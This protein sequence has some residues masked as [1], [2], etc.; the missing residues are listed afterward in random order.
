LHCRSETE[1]RNRTGDFYSITEGAD[2][3]LD[4]AVTTTE[5][6]GGSTQ[7]PRNALLT[8]PVKPPNE[9]ITPQTSGPN[10]PSSEQKPKPRGSTIL[11]SAD[12]RPQKVRQNEMTDEGAR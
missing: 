7:N 11:Q 8:T 4:K 3:T 10:L 5:K 12:R 2:T 9:A 6:N 1:L